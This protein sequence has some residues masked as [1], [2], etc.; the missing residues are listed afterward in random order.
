MGLKGCK[1]SSLKAPGTETPQSYPNWKLQEFPFSHYKPSGV[2][3]IGL[4]YESEKVGKIWK[5]WLNRVQ[6]VQF[7]CP[8]Q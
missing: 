2:I 4:Q 3:R 5:K 8:R 7:E 1:W 6:M